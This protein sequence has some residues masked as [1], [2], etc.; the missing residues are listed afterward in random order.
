[1]RILTLASAKVSHI[2][3]RTY[4]ACF[5]GSQLLSHMPTYFPFPILHLQ[6][7]SNTSLPC[8]VLLHA[9]DPPLE[10]LAS[11]IEHFGK[12]RALNTL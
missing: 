6:P 2:G 3:E 4:G 11:I 12:N 7:L 1:M 5:L 9:Y 10:F 8:K